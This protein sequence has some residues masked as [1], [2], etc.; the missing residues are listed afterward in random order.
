MKNVDDLFLK[1]ALKWDGWKKY[2][3]FNS[4][5]QI[6]GVITSTFKGNTSLAQFENLPS[7][8]KWKSFYTGLSGMDSHETF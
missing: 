2:K 8:E 5:N 7:L 3:V 4:K 1:W 6:R